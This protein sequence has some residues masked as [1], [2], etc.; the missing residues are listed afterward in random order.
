MSEFSSFVREDADTVKSR[1]EIDSIPIIDDIR[2]HITNFVQTF[3]DMYEADEKLGIVDAF[4]E[5]LNLDAWFFKKRF[6]FYG[7]ILINCG[8]YLTTCYEFWITVVKSESHL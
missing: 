7:F 2:F 8:Y 3:S 4:L 1:Q 5:E 6:T